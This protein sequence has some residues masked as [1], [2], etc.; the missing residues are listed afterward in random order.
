[1][2]IGGR[3]EVDVFP[4]DLAGLLGGGEFLIEGFLGK[5]AD[6]DTSAAAFFAVEIDHGDAVGRMAA[7]AAVGCHRALL[8]VISRGGMSSGFGR[9]EFLHGPGSD[10][11][12]DHA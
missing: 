6:A 2:G 12:G 11:D 1:M 8:A 3:I 9:A 4:V 10:G 7:G 5:V